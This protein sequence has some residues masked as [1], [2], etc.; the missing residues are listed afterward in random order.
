MWNLSDAQDISNNRESSIR[1]DN[2]SSR[3]VSSRVQ[4]S[5][6]PLIP[7]AKIIDGVPC[8]CLLFLR[9]TVNLKNKAGESYTDLMYYLVVGLQ[10]GECKITRVKMPTVY[11]GFERGCISGKFRVI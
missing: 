11:H 8:L 5:S 1:N 4:S 3:P 2:T 6:S 10:V 7:P 9:S